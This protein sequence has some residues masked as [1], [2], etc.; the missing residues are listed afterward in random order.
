MDSSCGDTSLKAARAVGRP[1][2]SKDETGLMGATCRHFFVL[3]ALDTH[4]GEIYEY[5]YILQV[6]ALFNS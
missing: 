1:H 5:P 2:A 3:K 4:R 6:D